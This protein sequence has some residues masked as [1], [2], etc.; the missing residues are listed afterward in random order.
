MAGPPDRL[1]PCWTEPD[2][3]GERE[4]A[5]DVDLNVDWVLTSFCSRLPQGLLH[6]FPR[7]WD[8][9]DSR[10]CCRCCSIAWP[11][12]L[13]NWPQRWLSDGNRIVGRF[14]SSQQFANWRIEMSK[15]FHWWTTIAFDGHDLRMNGWWWNDD[16]W[17]YPLMWISWAYVLGI[18]HGDIAVLSTTL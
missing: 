17:G 5:I 4:R 2:G 12:Q 16:W 1:Q 11:R 8:V 6:I 3:D 13:Q 10:P 14:A 18:F 7:R 15:G 9:P